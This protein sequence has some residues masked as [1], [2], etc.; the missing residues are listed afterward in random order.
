MPTVKTQCDA[1]G[2]VDLVDAIETLVKKQ[3]RGSNTLLASIL[4][5]AVGGTGWSVLKS[6]ETIAVVSQTEFAESKRA[7]WD[8]I[9]IMDD[10][11][12]EVKTNVAVI[13]T[14][15]SNLTSTVDKF[16]QAQEKVNE[17]NEAEDDKLQ[18]RLHHI[19]TKERP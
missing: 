15:V 18:E 11:R 17:K 13:A 4:A 10:Q 8:K 9:R 14:Q 7:T 6:P 3:G 12:M 19:E 2:T 5:I 1:D 16:V